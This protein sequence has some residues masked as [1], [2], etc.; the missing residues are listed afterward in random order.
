M[1]L[2]EIITI[3]NLNNHTN[4]T[5][6]LTTANKFLKENNIKLTLRNKKYKFERYNEWLIFYQDPLTY[7]TIEKTKGLYFKK[8]RTEI[9]MFR[10]VLFLIN[11]RKTKKE[12]IFALKYFHRNGITRWKFIKKKTVLTGGKDKQRKVIFINK[13]IIS[14]NLLNKALDD[15]IYIYV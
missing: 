10:G 3:R 14:Y 12:K 11:D 13:K 9:G 2:E 7:F 6:N 8:G 1:F 15:D 4:Q 5:F